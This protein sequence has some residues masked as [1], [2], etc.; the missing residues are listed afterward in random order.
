M[1]GVMQ[2]LIS[3]VSDIPTATTTDNEHTNI[4][5]V[6]IDEDN[7]RIQHMLPLLDLIDVSEAIHLNVQM[8]IVATSNNNKCG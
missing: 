3:T 1:V 6:N 7:S 5:C 8:T 2:L 4:V